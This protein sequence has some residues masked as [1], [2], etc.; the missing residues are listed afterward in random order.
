MISFTIPI[1]PQAWQRTAYFKGRQLTPVKTREFE[2]AVRLLSKRFAPTT[3]LN[4]PLKLTARFILPRP[5][6]P[7][8]SEP[9]VKPDL[10]NLMKSLKD[11]LNK[12]MW[13]DDSRVCRYGEGTGKYFDVSGG[14]GRI[15]VVIEQIETKEREK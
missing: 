10:D 1:K 13:T 2:K 6:R 3:P 9:A 8:F 14:P 5:K 15:E 7:M 11:G 12:V 4:G